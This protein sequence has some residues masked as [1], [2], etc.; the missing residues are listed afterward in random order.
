MD[1]NGTSFRG[2]HGNGIN[3][4]WNKTDHIIV[5]APKTVKYA[6]FYGNG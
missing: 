6:E 1:G 4:D 5:L 3:L 2:I